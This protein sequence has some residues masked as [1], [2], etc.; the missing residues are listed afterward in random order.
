MDSGIWVEAAFRRVKEDG[1]SGIME[2]GCM[3]RPVVEWVFFISR[4][5]HYP[6]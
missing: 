2:Y 1:P 5:G 3:F 6:L 4:I